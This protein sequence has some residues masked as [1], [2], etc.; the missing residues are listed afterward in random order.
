LRTGSTSAAQL[1][2]G[3]SAMPCAERLKNPESIAFLN[4]QQVGS[5]RQTTYTRSDISPRYCAME[6]QLHPKRPLRA[7]GSNLRQSTPMELYGALNDCL[8]NHRDADAVAL[9]ALLVWTV[10]LIRC[11]SPTDCGTSN[12]KF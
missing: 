2:G 5:G 6:A 3:E 9:F 12:V 10:P 1:P 8:E 11:A 7:T 4:G